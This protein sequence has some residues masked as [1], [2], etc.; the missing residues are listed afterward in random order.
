MIDLSV[1]LCLTTFG[2]G[3]QQVRSQ[4]VIKEF[5]KKS[6]Q[7]AITCEWKQVG[8]SNL[9]STCISMRVKKLIYSDYLHVTSLGV[10]SQKIVKIC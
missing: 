1:N 5:E 7:T 10:K 6:L 3:D 2:G 4:T 9:S 8:P